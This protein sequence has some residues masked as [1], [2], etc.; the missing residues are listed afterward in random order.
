MLTRPPSPRTVRLA[1]ALV[2]AA[3]L[4]SPALAQTGEDALNHFQAGRKQQA[5]DQALAVLKAEP[6]ELRSLFV[7]ARVSQ[8]RRDNQAALRYAEQL[9]R[10]YPG[11]P[12]GWEIT[13][14]L[15]QNAGDLPRR[16]A[17][18]R[19]LIQAQQSLMD[20]EQRGR[21]FVIR[22][23]IDAHGHVV[24]VQDHFDTGGPD[25]IRYVFIPEKE[26]QNVRNYLIVQTDT[27]TS[28]NWRQA[29]ILPRDK[30]LFHLDSVYETPGGGQ[31]QAMYATWTDPPDY[32]VVRA[33]VLEIMAG[34]V[35]P[36]SGQAGGLAV[37]ATPKP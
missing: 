17:A 33:K 11:L 31:T 7:A 27:N 37:P 29:G 35:K 2:A 25:A 1:V 26:A 5:Y 21:Q 8:E 20:R 10:L 32:D 36:M 30:R 15:F 13:T 9:T 23:R 22:D 18:L 12:A 28:D 34:T 14:Q 16:D 6:N 4:A 3:L 19:Q 24:F